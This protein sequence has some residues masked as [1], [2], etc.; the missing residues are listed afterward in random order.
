M[1]MNQKLENIVQNPTG[2]YIRPTQFHKLAYFF[3]SWPSNLIFDLQK[4]H[5]NMATIE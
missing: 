3:T 1:I 2:V 5:A 4:L